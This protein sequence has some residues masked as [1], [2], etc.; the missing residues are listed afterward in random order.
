MA[1]HH[2]KNQHMIILNRV[3]HGVRE[4]FGQTAANVRLQDG[5]DIRSAHDVPNRRL[6]AIDEAQL[7]S[8]LACPIVT[9]GVLVFDQ[10]IRMEL[11]FHLATARRT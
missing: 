10:G 8:I 5:P 1:V 11:E 2:G 4:H 3:E 6:H 9:R 7:E